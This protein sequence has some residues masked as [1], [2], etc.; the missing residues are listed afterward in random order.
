[1]TLAATLYY[2]SAPIE[3]DYSHT[4][5]TGHT[6]TVAYSRP[7]TMREVRLAD[8]EYLAQYQVGRYHSFMGAHMTFSELSE[9]QAWER[10]LNIHCQQ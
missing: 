3:A 6:V 9:Q 10:K 8:D 7:V 1:M 5:D 4:T 2:T